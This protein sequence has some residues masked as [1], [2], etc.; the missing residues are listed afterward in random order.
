M[1]AKPAQL[2]LVE[3]DQADALTKQIYENA[4]KRFQMV[5][6]IFKVTGH[7]SE[8]AEKM[9]NIF[10]EILAEGQVDW[11]TK[12]LLILKATKTGDCLYCVTQHEVVAERLGVTPE[13]QKDL[14]GQVYKDS[15]HFND[16][17]C[18][19][20]DLCAHMC[21]DP[22]QIPADVW[23]RVKSY[24]DDGQIVELAVTVGAYIQVSKFG[25]ALG[26]QLE[27]VFSGHQPRLFAKEP[28]K[29]AAA[30]HHLE[31][32]LERGKAAAH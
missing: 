15:P 8:I 4:E 17:E 29:S 23:T 16:K 26:V 12:E 20:V 31:H 10:F 19:I 2:P 18:A 28:P 22:E 5:L 27:D 13:K 30:R 7:A 11:Y 1:S 9:W 25:D 3:P 21:V 6:N 14:V 32:F 24:Y